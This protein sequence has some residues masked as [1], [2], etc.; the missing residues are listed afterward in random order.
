MSRRT[1]SWSS[2]GVSASAS[3]SQIGQAEAVVLAVRLPE[4]G[5]DATGGAGEQHE[6]ALG[7]THAG[8]IQKRVVLVESTPRD[9]SWI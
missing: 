7:L 5:A 6:A 2:P 4:C 3:V 8:A 1:T 9:G